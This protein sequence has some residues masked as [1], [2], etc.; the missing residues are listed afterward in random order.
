MDKLLEI[1][2]RHTQNIIYQNYYKVKKYMICKH[3]MLQKRHLVNDL[4]P[5]FPNFL[6]FDRN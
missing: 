2:H 4:V 6:F 3:D 1:R 5:K